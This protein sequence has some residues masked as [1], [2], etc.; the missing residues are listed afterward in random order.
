L[1]GSSVALEEA[2]VITPYSTTSALVPSKQWQPSDLSILY[3]S[4]VN[5]L[6]H[7]SD[8][9][10]RN[11]E[12]MS[13]SRQQIVP[14]ATRGFWP[15]GI[16]WRQLSLVRKYV[17]STLKTF[18]S[19]ILSD[20]TMPPF[21]HPT[22]MIQERLLP[23]T[24][25]PGPLSRCAGIVALWST[26]NKNNKHY[27]WK[28]IRMEQERL[29]EESSL[30]NDWN[31]VASLQAIVI[32]MLLRI[33][34]EPDED[35]NFDFP[36]TQTMT[37]LSQ[38]VQGFTVKYCDP[39]SQAIPVWENW[40][41]IESLRRTLST[42][43]IINFLFDIAP[44]TSSSN[45]D[46][47]KY[48]SEMLLPSTKQLWQARTGTQWE[49]EYRALNSDQRPMFGELLKHDDLQSQTSGLLDSWMGQVD[50][51]GT[52]VIGAASLADAME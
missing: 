17:L 25:Q 33:S 11:T 42:L 43:F 26:K 20:G 16:R 37:K 30:C 50:E 5:W 36:L 18:P 12:I 1:S 22:S 24:L 19:L 15:K 38:R 3:T 6:G 48:W 40:I 52:L 51:F 45:C 27:I 32:Y 10:S 41:L 21:I 23:E 7:D 13:P 46:S 14:Q 34:A 4:Q 9:W 44:G 2:E 28:I 8:I 47:V 29:A 31:A 35:A 49:Q 39:A